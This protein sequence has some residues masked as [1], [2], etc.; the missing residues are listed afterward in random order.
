MLAACV[1]ARAT[2]PSHLSLLRQ[3]QCIV[4]INPQV[5]DRAFQFGVAQEQLNGP[6]VLGSPIDQRGL[7]SPHGVGAVKGRVKS[8]RG[9]PSFHD[10]GILAGR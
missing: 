4:N 8:D 6:D 3:F 2:Q 7:G 10:T 5:S 9:N 1:S